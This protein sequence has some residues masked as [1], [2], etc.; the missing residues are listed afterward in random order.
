MP[1]F[2]YPCDSGILGANVMQISDTR[3]G[4][5]RM[6]REWRKRR[7]MSQLDLALDAEISQ[8]HLSFVESGRSSPSREMVLRLA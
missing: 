2:A 3:G 8:R 6:I 1:P 7:R 4:A 5:G